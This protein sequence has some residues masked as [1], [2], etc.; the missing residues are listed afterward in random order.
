MTKHICKTCGT[1]HSEKP[2]TPDR[3]L[4]CNDD[5]QYVDWEGQQWTT[6]E[7]LAKE[8]TQRIEFEEDL[9][10]IGMTPDFAIDQ[11]A[12]LLPTD[13]GNILWECVSL[14]TQEAIDQINKNGGLD[15]IVIS[16]PHFYS[17]MVEWSEA[18]D[19]VEILIHEADRQW[20]QRPHPS[21]KFWTGDELALSDSVT[22][23]RAGGHF[24][25]STVLH[26][27]TGPKS[28]GAL[29]SGD[30]LQVA[31]DRRH[32]SFM[33][34]YPN[35][36]PMKTSDV[37][38]MRNRLQKYQFEDVYGYTWNRNIIGNGRRMVDESYDRYL[39]AIRN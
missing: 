34:S 21:I 16:H 9:L 36:V 24:P 20:V 31:V 26:W 37:I 7:A 5:R 38:D 39:K 3:C 22:L 25:G 32:V 6:H 18:F 2:E 19:N 10:A 29:F 28:G 14:V 33:H 30:A 1:Q 23:I 4:I 11:R 12:F 17:S 15:R 35:M 8:Y 13:A 27:A